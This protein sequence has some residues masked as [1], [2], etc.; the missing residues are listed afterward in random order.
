MSWRAREREPIGGF[1]GHAPNGVQGQSPWAG[2]LL[3]DEVPQKL[4]LVLE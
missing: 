4:T 1:E 2:G 3:G